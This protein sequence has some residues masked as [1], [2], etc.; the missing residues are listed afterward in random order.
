[1]PKPVCVSCRCFYRTE[2]NGV[3][4][5]EGMPVRNGAPRGIAGDGWWTPYKL[6]R[7]DR[8]KCPECQHEIVTGFGRDPVA[9]HY[10]PQFEEIVE[11]MQPEFQVNDC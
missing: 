2:K 5:I 6:W 4:I 3:S 1:M 8:W 10:E 11:A 9:E 7:G